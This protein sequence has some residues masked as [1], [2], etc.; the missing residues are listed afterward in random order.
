MALEAVKKQQHGAIFYSVFNVILYTGFSNNLFSFF[1]SGAVIGFAFLFSIYLFGC[2]LVGSSIDAVIRLKKYQTRLRAGD[3]LGQSKNWKK[4]AVFTLCTK[5]LPIVCVLLFLISWL[6][7]LTLANNQIP[8][9]DYLD[10]PPFAVLEDIFPESEIDRTDNFIDYNTIVHYATALSDN[11]EW[12]QVSSVAVDNTSYHCTLR[13]D[14]HETISAFWAKGLFYDYYMYERLRFGETRYKELDTPQTG[15][16]DV[17]IFSSY[18]ILHV[19]IRQDATVTH[20]TVSIIQ[21][22]QNNQWQLWLEAMEEK[23]LH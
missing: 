8:L 14:H 5:F 12:N 11:Y 19:L 7:S 22:G 16:D 3:D 23:Q 17:K 6:N 4:N 13:I 15:F 9:V 20:A 2:W 1:R 18:G 10:A 21:Q